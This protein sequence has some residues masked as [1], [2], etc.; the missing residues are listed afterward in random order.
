MNNVAVA[1][2]A[3]LRPTT[4]FI[5]RP[6]TSAAEPA[7]AAAAAAARCP[8]HAGG[9]QSL[10]ADCDAAAVYDRNH[11]DCLHTAPHLYSENEHDFNSILLLL[12]GS[13]EKAWRKHIKR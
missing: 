1:T 4:S 6:A 5:T 10:C 13:G 2:A 7:A 3:A 11:S 8:H 12:A 9:M